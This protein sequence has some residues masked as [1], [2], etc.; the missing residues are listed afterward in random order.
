MSDHLSLAVL[1][2]GLDAA[3][4]EADDGTPAAWTMRYDRRGYS[5]PT[6]DRTFEGAQG[7]RRRRR[8]TMAV[9]ATTV[10]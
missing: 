3:W 1:P 5:C 9:I 7:K 8:I 6:A 2:H 10:T 4:V